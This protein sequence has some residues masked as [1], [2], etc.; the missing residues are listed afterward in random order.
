MSSSRDIDPEVAVKRDK[1]R[2]YAAEANRFQL[3]SASFAMTSEHG[4]RAIEF[5][6]GHWSCS[7]DFFVGH[8]TCSHI[9]ALIDILTRQAGVSVG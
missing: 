8:A 5:T 2:V 4:L 9:M 1:A 3:S 7:C 6:D